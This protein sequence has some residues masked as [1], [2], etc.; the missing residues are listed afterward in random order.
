[1]HAKTTQ[2]KIAD[3]FHRDS[4]VS[5]HE[6]A[7]LAEVGKI[8]AAHE[9][10]GLAVVDDRG[11]LVGEISQTDLVRQIAA[12]FAPS[13]DRAEEA[14]ASDRARRL[15]DE[16]FHRTARD[17]MQRKVRYVAPIDALRSVV[18]MMRLQR[19]HR[20]LVVEDG[21][22]IGIVTSFDLLRL[23][24]DPQFFHEFYGVDR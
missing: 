19:I 8:L 15:E 20:V 17:L 2:L 10:S 13:P 3:V 24:E 5:V 9:I 7:P 6:Q 4:L 1:M 16:F 14:S 22:P 18:H 11:F 21:R 23:I 12:A